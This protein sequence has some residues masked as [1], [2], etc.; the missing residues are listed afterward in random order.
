MTKSNFQLPLQQLEYTPSNHKIFC[1][2]CIYAKVTRKSVPDI[3]E[4]KRAL[5]F[6]GEV[7]SDLW[8][9][10]PVEYKSGK[11]YYMT[12]ID[13]KTRLTHLYFLR[14]KDE[15]FDAYKKYKAWVETQMNKKIKVLNSD[16][17]EEYQGEGM[18]NYLKS[19]G[20]EQTLNVHDTPQHAGVA[21]CQN[22]T[23]SECVWALLHASGLPKNLWAKAARHVVWLLNRMTIKAVEG[24]TLYKAVFGKKPDLSGLCKWGEK[25][26]V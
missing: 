12:F 25:V 23:I 7:H 9:K 1:E 11:L 17:G 19:K 22:K 5:D 6:S 10:S 2:S 15:T 4:W 3:H 16:R 14:K 26:Y 20:T 24:M 13:D 18:V 21:E 8:E